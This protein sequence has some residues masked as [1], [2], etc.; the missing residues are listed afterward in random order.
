MGAHPTGKPGEAPGAGPGL[1]PD[2]CISQGQRAPLGEDGMSQLVDRLYARAGIKGFT[3][4]DLRRTFA[5]Q[6]R[7]ATG[8]ECL[9]MRLL[10]DKIPG[11]ND[12]Y[13]VFPPAELV[14]ALSQYSPLHRIT[15]VETGEGRATPGTR[16]FGAVSRLIKKWGIPKTWKRE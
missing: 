6:V 10:R 8:D 1:T 7:L 13:L 2:G 9:A 4:H 15:M 16:G 12:R 5:T 3:G 11:V 14:D